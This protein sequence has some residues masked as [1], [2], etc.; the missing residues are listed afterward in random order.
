[1]RRRAV[2]AI[3]C[4]GRGPDSVERLQMPLPTMHSMQ[5][6][7]N[8][9]SAHMQILIVTE[10]KMRRDHRTVY[11]RYSQTGLYTMLLLHVYLN[12][13]H[14]CYFTDCFLSQ[15]YN[16]FGMRW[17]CRSHSQ[18]TIHRPSPNYNWANT[19]QGIHVKWRKCQS[20]AR[21]TVT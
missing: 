15:L 13:L 17:C 4:R 2:N 18:P 3:R 10:M 20:N 9:K 7:N 8:I 14:I 19:S 16:V 5:I 1:M 12:I 6:I 11:I 21:N